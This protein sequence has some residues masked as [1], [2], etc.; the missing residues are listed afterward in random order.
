MATTHMEQKG[1]VDG[2]CVDCK[3]FYECHIRHNAEERNC[4]IPEC[5]RFDEDMLAPLKP[6]IVELFKEA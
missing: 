6:E 5:S 2:L 1:L 4:H 3:F